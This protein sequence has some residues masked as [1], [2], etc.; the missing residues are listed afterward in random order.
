MNIGFA[1]AKINEVDDCMQFYDIK[2]VYTLKEIREYIKQGYYCPV[3]SK[4]FFNCIKLLEQNRLFIEEVKKFRKEF[5]VPENISYPKYEEELYRYRRNMDEFEANPKNAHKIIN[6]K[7]LL[8][9][10][11]NLDRIISY[12]RSYNCHKKFSKKNF[13]NYVL[14]IEKYYCSII[15]SFTINTFLKGYILDLFF[16]GIIPLKNV[17]LH[18]IFHTFG[19]DSNY[20]VRCLK[21][22]ITSPYIK[23]NTLLSYIDTNWHNIKAELDDLIPA[24]LIN[25]TD[26]DINFYKLRQKKSNVEATKIISNKY[27]DPEANINTDSMK[28]A[29]HRVKQKIQSL[30]SKK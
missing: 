6:N 29:Y 7:I 28:T 24:K 9:R 3:K 21:I 8:L 4:E 5:N 13:E 2:T 22:L 26:R 15:K 14:Q 19:N 10:N 17:E 16:S 11:D 12:C 1:V 20:D 25:I 30:F 23:K 18:H 27:D